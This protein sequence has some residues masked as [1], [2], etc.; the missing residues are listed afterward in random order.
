MKTQKTMVAGDLVYSEI[1]GKLVRI[2]RQEGTWVVVAD[3]NTLK[4]LPDY[5]HETQIKTTAEFFG[6]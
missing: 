1:H 2:V 3:R 6:S 5:V 4:E